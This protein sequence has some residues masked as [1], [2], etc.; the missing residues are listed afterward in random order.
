MAYPSHKIAP[1]FSEN[2]LKT[3]THQPVDIRGAG[4]IFFAPGKSYKLFR[5]VCSKSDMFFNG[6][7]SFVLRGMAVH[8]AEHQ[9]GIAQDT[10]EKI[11]KV[12]YN[13]PCRFLNHLS[14]PQFFRSPFSMTTATEKSVPF[15]CAEPPLMM[16][17]TF[18][19]LKLNTGEPLYPWT[20]GKSS[21]M[22]LLAS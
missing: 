6:F 4:V 2:S 15:R 16:P 19:F 7:Q 10:H 9:R 1:I 18:L 5:Q 3:L 20:A 14:I 17:T 12:M 21:K 8:L 22:T 11:I 13:S